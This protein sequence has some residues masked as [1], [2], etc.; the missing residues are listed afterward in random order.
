MNKQKLSIQTLV[1]IVNYKTPELTSKAVLSALS[2]I[3]TTDVICV[4]DNFSND[5]SCEVIGSFIDR[6][7]LSDRV[8]LLNLEKNLGYSS[9]NNAGIE[10]AIRE[11]NL[12][13]SYYY[14]LN[15]D[16][17]V[18]KGS[19]LEL[20]SFLQKTPSAAIAGSC[21]V[22]ETGQ[23]RNSAFRF[24]SWLSE[25]ESSLRFSPVSRLLAKHRVS[26]DNSKISA[27][28]QTDWVAGASMMIRAE[29]YHQLGGLDNHYFL[30]FE[31]TDFC[32][33]ALRANWQCWY[34]PTSVV[35][36]Y[37][38]KSTGVSSKDKSR[39]RRPAYWFESRQRY[40]R[41]NHGLFYTLFADSIFILGFS[42]WRLRRLIQ[43]KPD[44]DPE[45]FL[46]DFIKNSSLISWLRK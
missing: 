37:E 2:E 39:R 24:P 6:N 22:D 5:N 18:H 1:I 13:P 27:P 4:V 15:P 11:L 3:E 32:K 23:L 40:F 25:L 29:A 10:Y 16:T 34:V 20:V 44:T 19:T 21:I 26:F 28:C 9:G 7:Q 17:M 43:R 8:F 31:E 30:Y 45:L 36:H 41:K 46:S 35:M 42:V 33:R 14:L 38:G 12:A